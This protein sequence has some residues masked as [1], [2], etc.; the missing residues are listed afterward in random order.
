MENAD[1]IKNWSWMRAALTRYSVYGSPKGLTLFR[2]LEDA[3]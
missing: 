1:Q 3:R 2:E